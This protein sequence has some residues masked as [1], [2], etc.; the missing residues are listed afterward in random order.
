MCVWAPGRAWCAHPECKLAQEAKRAGLSSSKARI[1]TLKCWPFPFHDVK[2]GAKP[3][4]YRLN[5]RDYHVGD[6]LVL[7]EYEPTTAAYTKE[8]HSVR[9]TY[10]LPGGTFG[11]PEGYCIMGIEPW[12]AAEPIGS[13]VGW[14]CACAPMCSGEKV[15]LAKKSAP[16]TSP[17]GSKP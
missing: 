16:F 5:D 12:V 3:F 11:V 14:W 17:A 6:C 4:E 7:Q 9:V 10:V 13:A 15:H 8:C 2:S 1:H